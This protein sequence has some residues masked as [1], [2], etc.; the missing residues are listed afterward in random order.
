MDHAPKAP[1]PRRSRLA[2]AAVEVAR[3]GAVGLMLLAARS[4]LA[5]H[6]Y[7]PSG[8]MEPTLAVGDRL[9][10]NKLAY[11]LRVPFTARSLLRLGQPARGDV[12]VLTSPQDG[13]VLVKRVV[14]VPGDVVEVREG[15]VVL[16]GQEVAL[17]HS[18]A[19]VTEQLPGH[20]HPIS[21]LSGGGPDYGPLQL[22]PDQYL[23]MGDNRG[24]SHDGRS[25]GL[26]SRSELLGR[27][28]RLY[29]HEGRFGWYSP[30]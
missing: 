3:I 2:S 23:V 19:E 27:V 24:N 1:V 5:D 7:V 13:T 4:S 11:D 26:I 8:S 25:F 29:R 17:S 14:A 22:P 10:V 6:Y 18:G 28:E 16:N 20:G 30:R 21:L 9:V 15:R 12:A